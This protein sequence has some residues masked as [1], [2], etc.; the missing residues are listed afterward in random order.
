ME[1][2][3]TKQL[4][5]HTPDGQD[6]I[7]YTLVN[8]NGL[9]MK[10]I[11]LGCTITEIHVPDRNGQFD[12]VVLG[13]DNL[14]GYLQSTEYIGCIVGRFANRIAFG[15]FV[16]D[17]KGYMLATNLHPHH[18]HG[19]I[20]GFSHVV[21]TTEEIVYD[22]G[23][24]VRFQYVSRDGEEGYPGTLRLEVIYT[25]DNENKILFEYKVTTDQPTIINLTQHTYF[26]LS[27]GTNNVLEHELTVY[28]DEFLPTDALM[29][30][31]GEK[32][33]VAG[34]PF[35]F[36]EAKPI[37]RDIQ[38]PDEHLMAGNGYDHTFV[39]KPSAEELHRAATLYEKNSGRIMEVY[40]TEPGIQVYSSNFLKS[41]MNGKK[42]IPL[43][44]RMA[45]C[46]ETQHFPDSP[47]RPSFPTVVLRPGED[48]YS[49]TILAFSTA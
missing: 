27:N 8:R 43:T 25:L 36:R 48:Y 24:G 37:G 35:D 34:T 42:N 12:D 44:P 22:H 9:I 18:L 38:M 17:G 26:N 15:K 33:S 20:K 11:N 14:N 47:N 49:R 39:L 5:G 4:Y 1:H 32:N 7:E 40:T 46:L 21:W 10:V 3:I 45:I 16:L 23:V 2:K 41:T 13:Y 31:T 28:A 30:P 29:I 19:G 6:V